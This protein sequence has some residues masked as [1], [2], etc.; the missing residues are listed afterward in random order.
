LV[1]TQ[2]RK[3]CFSR[4]RQSAFLMENLNFFITGALRDREIVFAAL[5]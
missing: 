2:S 4:F 3:A 5:R 1:L